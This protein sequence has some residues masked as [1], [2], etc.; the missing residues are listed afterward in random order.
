MDFILLLCYK[1]TVFIMWIRCIMSEMYVICWP[2]SCVYVI[3]AR[4]RK[5]NECRKKQCKNK[6]LEVSHPA[7][8]VSSCNFC[9]YWLDIILTYEMDYKHEFIKAQSRKNQEMR[10]VFKYAINKR[11]CKIHL[12]HYKKGLARNKPLLSGLPILLIISRLP[13]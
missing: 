6:I 13:L 9:D 5:R 7:T 12:L 3:V 10:K 2:H 8:S 1:W 4:Q 11:G